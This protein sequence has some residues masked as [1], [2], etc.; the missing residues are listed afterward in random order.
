MKLHETLISIRD[1]DRVRL[2]GSVKVKGTLYIGGKNALLECDELICGCLGFRDTTIIGL[3]K[4]SPNLKTR[5][6]VLEY[7]ACWG[8][9]SVSIGMRRFSRLMDHLTLCPGAYFSMSLTPGL[10]INFIHDSVMD[11]HDVFHYAIPGRTDSLIVTNLDDASAREGRLPK[12]YTKLFPKERNE[13][14]KQRP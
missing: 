1:N 14:I 10:D 4:N 3:E 5:I 2:R 11:A 8:T 6:V 13:T 7:L 9:K 12:N